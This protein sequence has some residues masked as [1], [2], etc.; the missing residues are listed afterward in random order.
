MLTLETTQNSDTDS[1][2]D[3][4]PV[5]WKFPEIEQQGYR[6]YFFN[7][8]RDK[9]LFS[10]QYY[11]E[12]SIQTIESLARRVYLFIAERSEAINRVSGRVRQHEITN[13]IQNR[14]CEVLYYRG[15]S[16]RFY[17]LQSSRKYYGR[18]YLIMHVIGYFETFLI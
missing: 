10:G 9:T 5:L 11:C 7:K 15:L 1:Q 16:A 8:Y 2:L 3:R 12:D 6:Y 4:G 14:A 13:L 17:S 18:N